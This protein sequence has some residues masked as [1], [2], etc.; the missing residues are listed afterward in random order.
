MLRLFAR[1]A[2]AH[3]RAVSSTAALLRESGT[4]K[5]FNVSKGFGFILPDTAPDDQSDVFVHYSDIV[6]GKFF[7]ALFFCASD[8]VVRARSCSCVAPAA[9]PRDPIRSHRDLSI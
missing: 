3:A 7:N 1:S 6:G 4:V 9:P 2:P 8:P 5:W